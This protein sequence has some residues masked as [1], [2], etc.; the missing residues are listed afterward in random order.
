[1]LISYVQGA[2]GHLVL[3]QS[4]LYGPYSAY[5]NFLIKPFCHALTLDNTQTKINL[6]K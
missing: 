5:R 2:L 4:P 6:I 3:F 1:M